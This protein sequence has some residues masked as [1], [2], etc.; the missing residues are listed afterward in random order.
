[1][2][3]KQVSSV[4]DDELTDDEKASI[5]EVFLS[6]NGS[7]FDRRSMPAAALLYACSM[8]VHNLPKL[9]RIVFETRAEFVDPSILSLL[10]ETLDACGRRIE[11]EIAIGV[12]IFDERL[13]NK[14]YHK[15]LSNSNLE[16]AVTSIVEAGVHLRCY[17]MYRPLPEMTP[18]TAAAD[19]RLAADF[20]D[21]FVDSAGGSQITMHLNPT[22]VAVG[23][24][25]ERSFSDGKYRPV[26]LTEVENLLATM[27]GH[28]ID[29]YVGLNDEGLAVP[30]GSFLTPGSEEVIG[31]LKRFNRTRDFSL[32]SS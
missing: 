26:Q 23:T 8:L 5:R 22:Y 6:N 29:I 10:R 1:M 14:A 13:R 11:I 3:M 30:G 4:L 16:K 32:L 31:R 12:E 9:N 27:A 18:E 24:D 28:G 25:L 2:I 17:F 19:I 20:L 15:G 21:K 7:I